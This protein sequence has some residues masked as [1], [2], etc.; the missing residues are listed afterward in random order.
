MGSKKVELPDS[1]KNG[2]Y[3]VNITEASDQVYY[4]RLRV[5]I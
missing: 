1:L 2:V 5:S 3:Y 4:S